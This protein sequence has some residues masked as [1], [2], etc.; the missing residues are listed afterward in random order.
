M[1]AQNDIQ[2]VQDAGNI[3]FVLP[4]LT[5]CPFGLLAIWRISCLAFGISTTTSGVIMRWTATHPAREPGRN[6]RIVQ[7]WILTGGS[8]TAKAYFNCRSRL[9]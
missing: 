2:H 5:L 6:E 3:A 1:L 9:E 4:I 8:V 7:I